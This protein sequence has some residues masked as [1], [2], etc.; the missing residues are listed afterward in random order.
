[1]A[2]LSMEEIKNDP[3]VATYIRQADAA[4][5]AYGYTEH[6]FPHV[7]R[8]AHVAAE[9]L[10][11]M[12]ATEREIELAQIAVSYTHLDVYKRQVCKRKGLRF[13]RCTIL[14]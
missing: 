14:K 5:K 9:I 11:T 3:A 12:G 6:S 2:N 8:T 4:M 7:T 1:M 10:R 13:L